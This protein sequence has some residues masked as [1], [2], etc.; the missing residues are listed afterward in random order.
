MIQIINKLPVHMQNMLN[1]Y[2]IVYQLAPCQHLWLS[3]DT[4]GWLSTCDT[5]VISFSNCIK[6]LYS[7]QSTHVPET[8]R[9]CL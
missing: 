4:H 9:F 1:S 7:Q 6:L 5:P 2:M 3:A 8:P